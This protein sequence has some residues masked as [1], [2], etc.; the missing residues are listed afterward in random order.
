MT[1]RVKNMR[2]KIVHYFADGQ[3]CTGSNLMY[4]VDGSNRS[5][6]VPWVANSIAIETARIEKLLE[7]TGQ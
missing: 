2:I 1:G 4:Q 5:S 7:R 6:R 3:P